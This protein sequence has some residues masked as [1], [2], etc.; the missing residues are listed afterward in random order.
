MNLKK[1][2]IVAE[3]NANQNTATAIDT[4]FV[5]QKSAVAILPKTGPEW[6]EKKA[7]LMSSLA[8]NIDVV[9][10]QVPPA[11]LATVNLP[12]RASKA[13]GVYSFVNYLSISGQAAGNLTPYENM[14]IW[15]TP[16]TVV[17]KGK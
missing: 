7:E 3:I 17:Y 13:I 8:S 12:E 5:Y 4:V 1:I 2:Q 14:V 6:F 9:S 15:L 11:T 10:V 16:T